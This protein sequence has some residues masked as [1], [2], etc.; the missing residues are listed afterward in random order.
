VLDADCPIHP[1]AQR[2]AALLRVALYGDGFIGLTEDELREAR[3]LLE[4]LPA[5]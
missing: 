4:A 2:L 1:A 5:V 3:G